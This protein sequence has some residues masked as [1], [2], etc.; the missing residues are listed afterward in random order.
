MD[1]IKRSGGY[2]TNT[3]IV[4]LTKEECSWPKERLITHCDRNGNLTESQWQIFADGAHPGHFGGSVEKRQGK[5]ST[6]TYAKIRV[7][8]D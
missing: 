6:D 4:R 2:G 5:H 3:F 7:H 1:F 8:F